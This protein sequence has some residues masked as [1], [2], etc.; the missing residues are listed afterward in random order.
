LTVAAPL[1]AIHDT[2]RSVR[3]TASDP[4][5]IATAL[6]VAFLDVALNMRL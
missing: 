5:T 4:A 2:Q 6:R 1:A 3:L